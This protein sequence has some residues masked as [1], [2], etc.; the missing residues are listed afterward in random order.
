MTELELEK[1]Y[2]HSINNKTEIE[3]S[4]TC[5]CFHCKEIFA[6]SEIKEWIQDS[7]DQTAQC[8]YCMVDAVIGN[9]SEITISLQFLKEMHKKYFEG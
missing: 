1:A 3:K 8:P 6:P 5:G 7:K 4:D 9:A 2:K